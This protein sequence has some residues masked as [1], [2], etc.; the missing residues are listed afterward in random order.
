MELL[1]TLRGCKETASGPDG[2]TY[3]IY[4]CLWP[5]IG[6]DIVQS[7]N[8]SVKTG[9]MPPSHLESVLTLLPKDGKDTKEIKNWR[10][11]TLTNCD[12]KII[13]KA[14]AVRMSK[15]LGKIIHPAQTAY[16]PMRSVMDN[17]RSNIYYRDYCKKAGIN[18]VIVSL[19]AKKAFNSVSHDY[20]LRTLKAYGVG[21]KFQNYFKVL[22]NEVKV[23]ILVNGYFSE[24]IRIERGVKQGDALSCSLFILSIDP[25]IRNLNNNSLY[26][27]N[28]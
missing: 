9:L 24:G 27:G 1:N 25:L 19:D 23:K 17:L 26:T 11:I 22:Y 6:E 4:K 7:W 12:A 21:E 20:I 8:F 28:I 5:I 15:H 13:T 10:P 2:L 16:I 14:L 18:G 3:K